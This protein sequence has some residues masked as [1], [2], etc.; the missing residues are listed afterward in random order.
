MSKWVLVLF[1]LIAYAFTSCYSEYLH[2]DYKVIDIAK[3]DT[4]NNLI[5]FTASTKAFRKAK[6]IAAFPDGGVSK[7]IMDDCNLWL[8]DK[9]AKTLTRL[10]SLYKLYAGISSVPFS[11][12]IVFNDSLVFFR[13][14]PFTKYLK[15]DSSNNNYLPKAYCANIRNRNVSEIDTILFMQYYKIDTSREFLELNQLKEML[16]EFELKEWGFILEDLYPKSDKNYIDDFIYV[17]K[18]GNQLTRRAIVEQII[19]TK[20]KNEIE[21]I[22]TK[23]DEYK[24]SLSGY[25]KDEYMYC[26]EESYYLIKRLLD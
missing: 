5:P 16:S 9:K 11:T 26:T 22:I 7:Y 17:A 2:L 1:V 24:N 19:A 15:I 21:A 8:L 20:S 23:M 6:G 12:E 14:I 4:T 25:K 10:V 13:I 3:V 18:G